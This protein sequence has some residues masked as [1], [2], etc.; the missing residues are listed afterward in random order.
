MAIVSVFHFDDL[1]RIL[2]IWFFVLRVYIIVVV[3][4]CEI[5]DG[6]LRSDYLNLCFTHAQVNQN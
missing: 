5:V 3:M 6:C 2:I 1:V 4:V